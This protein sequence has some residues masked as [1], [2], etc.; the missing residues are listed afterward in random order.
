MIRD[1]R[2]KE[3]PNVRYHILRDVLDTQNVKNHTPTHSKY[4]AKRP[5]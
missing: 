5:K 1:G 3:L 2:V 4:N